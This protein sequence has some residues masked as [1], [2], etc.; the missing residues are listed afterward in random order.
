MCALQV[1]LMTLGLHKTTVGLI[2]KRSDL[3]WIRTPPFPST[4]FFCGEQSERSYD[5]CLAAFQVGLAA[6]DDAWFSASE[7]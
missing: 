4:A 6:V 5:G 2:L 1:L 3:K 7:E